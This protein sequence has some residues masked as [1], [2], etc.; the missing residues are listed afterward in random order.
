MYRPKSQTSI[1]CSHVRMCSIIYQLDQT[2]F[3]LLLLKSSMAY[4]TI[5]MQLAIKSIACNNACLNERRSTLQH[6]YP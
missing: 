5:S 1:E 3:H 2:A 4:L 6:V